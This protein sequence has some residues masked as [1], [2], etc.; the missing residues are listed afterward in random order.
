[1]N[2]QQINSLIEYFETVERD[3]KV[4]ISLDGFDKL[5]TELN[6]SLPKLNKVSVRAL[7]VYSHSA[8]DNRRYFFPVTSESHWA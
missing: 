5:L 4:G 8:S 3:E 6:Q 7:A 2:K 1:M